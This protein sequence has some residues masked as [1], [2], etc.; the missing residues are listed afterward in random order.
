MVTGKVTS[1]TAPI[2]MEVE[3]LPALLAQVRVKS[4]LKSK[5]PSWISLTSPFFTAPIP[6]SRVQAGSGAGWFL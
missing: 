1:V 3:E 5:R 2:S 6:W 4:R